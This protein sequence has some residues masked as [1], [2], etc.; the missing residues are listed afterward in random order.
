[1]TQNTA[2]ANGTNGAPVQKK[3]QQETWNGAQRYRGKA[4]NDPSCRPQVVVIPT[5]GT[6]G[7][8]V[9]LECTVGPMALRRI[10][11][12]GWILNPKKTRAENERLMADTVSVLRA[13]GWR[14]RTLGD[15]TGIGDE[16]VEWTPTAEEK[17]DEETGKMQRFWSASFVRAV[18][19]LSTT[20]AATTKDLE[21]LNAMLAGLDQGDAAEP[22]EPAGAPNS[23]P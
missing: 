3:V 19:K 6:K 11:F 8:E 15:W 23:A 22:N 9:M 1:M 2:T 7:I 12:K 4:V 10:K 18:P 5:T 14:G 17:L 20:N 21:E 16:F 13:M